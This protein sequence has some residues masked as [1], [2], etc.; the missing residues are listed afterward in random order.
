MI[1][2]H[3]YGSKQQADHLHQSIHEEQRGHV[4]TDVIVRFGVEE[5]E[6]RQAEH[7]G[8]DEARSRDVEESAQLVGI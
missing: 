6:L 3:P 5:Y 2:R 7:H 8:K 4:Y 1:A